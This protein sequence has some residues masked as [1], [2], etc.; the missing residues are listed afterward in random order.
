MSQAL[1]HLRLFSGLLERGQE[2]RNEQG[3][4]GNDHEQF[5]QG[6]TAPLNN[7]LADA[8][9]L[10]LPLLVYSSDPGLRHDLHSFVP[11]R[12]EVNRCRAAPVG[13]R[14]RPRADKP[15]GSIVQ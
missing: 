15:A 1:D 8:S 4:N 9:A 13:T 3:D 6:K 14:R 11:A 12:H 7:P 5:D 10:S 2:D